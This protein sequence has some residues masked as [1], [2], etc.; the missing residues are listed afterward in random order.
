MGECVYARED[1]WEI[2]CAPKVVATFQNRRPVEA[3]LILNWNE[4]SRRCGDMSN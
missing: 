4:T 3:T 1:G 2:G